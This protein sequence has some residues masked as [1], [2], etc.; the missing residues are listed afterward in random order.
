[1]LPG[2]VAGC[3]PTFAYNRLSHFEQTSAPPRLGPEAGGISMGTEKVLSLYVPFALVMMMAVSARAQAQ[4]ATREAV[5]EQA[6]AAKSRTLQPYTPSRAER[7]MGKVEEVLS[8]TENNWHPYFESAYSGGGF[9]FG[10][11]FARHVSPYN[12]VD[13]R[14]SYT[15]RGYKRAEAEFG[16][17]RLFHRRG[18]LS[19]LGGWREATQVAFYGLGTNTTDEHRL[20]YDFQQPYASALLTVRPDRRSVLLQGGLELTQWK[21][22]QG[23]GEFPSVETVF[24]PE[25]LP[26]IGARVNYLHVQGTA[27]FDWRTSPGYSRRGGF[28]G[29]TFHAYQDP[30]DVFGF[31]QIDY[32]AIQ[33][34]PILRDAWVLSLHARASTTN[35]S[36]GQQI[37]FFML[38]ALGGGSTLRGFSSWRFRD[39]DSLLLQ[40][41]WR[42]VVNR[43]LDSAFFFDAGKVATHKSQLDF[44][45]LRSDYGFGLRFHGPFNTPFRVDVARSNEGT[46]LVF[47]TSA[48]F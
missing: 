3:H 15:L 41:E 35:T 6:Q 2:P 9:A 37:P 21:Q 13:V 14:G 26:G 11:G 36:A 44:N 1:M 25:T 45:G 32:E 7:L 20:N 19:I 33:H 40:A 18:S 42:I 16:A 48:A 46:R 28:Y 22:R 17:P 4:D 43:F 24:T 27:G 34:F 10:S 30:D 12:T 38:P 47:T 23:E 5:I 8:A 29:V 39:R 31:Q